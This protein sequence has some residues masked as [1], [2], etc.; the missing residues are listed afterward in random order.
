MSLMKKGTSL[1]SV[2]ANR[3]NGAKSTGPTSER[4]KAVSRFNAA[5]HWG[6]AAVMFDLMPALGEA[7]EDFAAVLAGLRCALAPRDA[8]E[9][10]LVTDMAEIHWRL[11]R[12]I[13]G[14]A[15]ALAVKRRQ[16]QTDREEEEAR[17]AA[18]GL[19][20]LEPS[21][22][23]QVGFVGLHDSPAKFMQI[24][25]LLKAL[26]AI[27]QNE[28]FPGDGRAFF[29][30]IYG[31]EPGIRGEAVMSCFQRFHEDEKAGRSEI[32]AANRAEFHGL[33]KSEIAW[34]EQGAARD[35]RARAELQAPRD[36]APLAATKD[37]AAAMMYLERLERRFERKWKLLRAYRK[38]RVLAL[39]A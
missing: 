2:E 15:A 8:F 35:R 34:F 14:E 7:P 39:A 29:A 23:A 11:R 32:A 6:R 38:S 21:V 17:M 19:H 13:R 26:D 3:A 10:L 5:R 33:L 27:I 30:T 31:R 18:G 37:S 28:G 22:A 20:P 9:E 24:I 12:V 1:A 4:G 36:A 16:K 25:E